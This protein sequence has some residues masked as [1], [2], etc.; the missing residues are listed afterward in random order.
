[1]TEIIRSVT[2]M[3]DA[4]VLSGSIAV[5]SST[6]V[7][8]AAANER[9]SGL[10]VTAGVRGVFVKFQ[11]ASVDNDQKG[12]FIPRNLSKEFFSGQAKVTGEISVISAS[13]NTT[14]NVTEF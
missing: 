3:N 14:V 6:S 11:A 9:R 8:I 10:I 7:T 13:G 4:P 12:Y 2:D 1:M 5:T